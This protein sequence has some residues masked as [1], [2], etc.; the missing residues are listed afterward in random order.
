MQSERAPSPASSTSDLSLHEASLTATEAYVFLYP[1]VFMEAFRQAWGERPNTFARLTPMLMRSLD[2]PAHGPALSYSQGA[3]IDLSAG[4]VALTLP[5]P[6]GRHVIAT[7]FD[8]WGE[9]IASLGSRH[10]GG[11]GGRY[12]LLGPGA[13]DESEVDFTAIR[14]PTNRVWMTASI[15]ARNEADFDVVRSLAS[16][17][18]AT[19]TGDA[20]RAFALSP[21]LGAG[22][23]PLMRV[24]SMSE[25]EFFNTAAALLEHNPLRSADAAQAGLLQKL[26]VE[27]GRRFSLSGFHNDVRLFIQE[28][29]A[30]GR[31]TIFAEHE[32]LMRQ[33][34]ESWT[35]P[36]SSNA[37]R[38]D[39]LQRAARIRLAPHTAQP[40]D[41]MIFKTSRDSSGEFLHGAG[42]YSIRFDADSMPPTDTLWTISAID[43]AGRLVARKPGRSIGNHRELIRNIDGSLTIHVESTKSRRSAPGMNWLQCPQGRFNLV[44]EL[45]SPNGEALQG[46]WIPPLIEREARR[47][48]T[49]D[50]ASSGSVSFL[51]PRGNGALA[52]KVGSN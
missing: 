12:L 9:R 5:D 6:H 42:H 30:V 23:S 20:P 50:T 39:Y 13:T 49:T 25:E 2:G 44:L 33:V 52:P 8:A 40:A 16:K 34:R 27:A 22:L 36:I 32:R 37:G 3:W 28:G 45:F 14:S 1:L 24:S 31:A 11:K 46:K 7:A 38:N 15:V 18:K 47:T 4:P 48:R 43:L 29:A 21:R 19:V 51:R 10:D 17:F 41:H 35:P 26:G